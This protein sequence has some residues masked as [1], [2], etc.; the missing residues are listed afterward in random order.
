MNKD[1]E[2]LQLELAWLVRYISSLTPN[3]TERTLD[4]SGFLIL[5]YIEAQGSAGIK[6]LASYFKLDISTMSRQVRKLEQKDCLKRIP[7][8]EDK[9]AFS[10]SLTTSGKDILD[11][12]RDVKVKR[13]EELFG[14][15]KDQDLKDFSRLLEKA[16]KDIRRGKPR[17]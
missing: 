13:I 12:Y 11:T 7:K 4:R 17:D 16:N 9:R 1:F 5:Q 14:H 3:Q 15:W 6:E 10:L 2:V 8:P